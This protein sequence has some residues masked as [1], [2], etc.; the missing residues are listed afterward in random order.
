MFSFIIFRFEF[1]PRQ[2]SDLKNV[3]IPRKERAV[4]LSPASEK[5][6]KTKLWF[7]FF[8]I[9]WPDYFITLSPF[10]RTAVRLKNLMGDTRF[11]D[12]LIFR[13]HPGIH[14][15][16][17]LS[18]QPFRAFQI[19]KFRREL[20]FK[21]RNS[22]SALILSS[23]RDDRATLNMSKKQFVTLVGIEPTSQVSSF[24]KKGIKKGRN[25]LKIAPF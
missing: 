18:G 1:V 21:F 16:P 13:L 8:H 20:F 15:S 9:N 10:V 14:D 22:R 4:L 3:S 11:W 12:N 7:H 25:L 17:G 2:E 19:S 6:L 5:C 24:S 23:F